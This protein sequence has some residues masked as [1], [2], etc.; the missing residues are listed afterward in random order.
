MGQPEILLV[1][2]GSRRAGATLAL[3]G[4]AAALSERAGLPVAPVSLQHAD[5]IAA[6]KLGG[7][8]AEIFPAYIER[9][10]REGQREFL[11]VPLFFG[12]SKALSSF[13]PQQ[14]ERLSAEHGA[15]DVELADVLVPLPVGEP[16]LAQILADN[17]LGTRDGQDDGATV[18][19]VDHG[20]PLPQVTEVRRYAAEA[21]GARLP[22]GFTL[23]Q[24][25]ME[26]REGSEY[27]FNGDLLETVLE[28]LAGESEKLDVILAMFFLLPGRHAGEG[29]DIA[30]ICDAAMT[31]HPQLRISVSPLV[32][33]HPLLLEVLQDRLMAALGHD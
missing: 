22:A 11:L 7:R 14:V 5:R 27:D 16:R 18:I 3:R 31:R 12:P 30:E 19:V 21:L 2:N 25:V 15:F 24:A 1:D 9:R 4:L 10:L 28:N 26:R 32:A 8:A 29:G 33:E 17:V 13:I 6:D 20:S 23:R